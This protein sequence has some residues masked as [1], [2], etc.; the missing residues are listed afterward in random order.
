MSKMSPIVVIEL[1]EEHRAAIQRLLL[2]ILT[3]FADDKLFEQSSEQLTE[4]LN[5]LCVYY[6]FVSLL[7]LLDEGGR[8]IDGNIPGRFY[9]DHPRVG[10]GAD[11]SQRPYFLA[12]QQAE[13]AVITEP[14]LSS[15]KN[16]LC[17]S[18]SSKVLGSVRGY[19]VL[20]VDLPATLS[21]LTGDSKRNYFEPGFKTIYTLIVLGLF[22]VSLILLY[23]A[24]SECFQVLQKAVTQQDAKLIPFSVVIY[25]TLALAIFDLGKT[26]LE[27]EVLL[28]KDILKHSSTRR[29]ITRFIAAIIIALSIEAL[30]MI[31][32]AALQ[33]AAGQF[34]VEAVWVVLAAA[35]LLLSLGVYV[36]LGSR[37]EVLLVSHKQRARNE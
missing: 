29:T 18:V 28:Y 8:Q 32:K 30:L 5:S 4:T 1:Y 35:F 36:Y 34:I 3:C 31:F 23:A 21:F 26:T 2:S 25:L 17:I 33:G 6:P 12:A 11:R 16:E 13:G 14:Y 27:E 9:K 10:S 7:Y 22:M 37:A 19:V 24:G 15:I 20:D